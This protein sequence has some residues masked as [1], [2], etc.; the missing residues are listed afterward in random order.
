VSKGR[1]GQRAGWK[2][3]QE[4]EKGGAGRLPCLDPLALFQQLAHWSVLIS[5]FI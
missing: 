3:R 1:R 4:G 5:K 2:E